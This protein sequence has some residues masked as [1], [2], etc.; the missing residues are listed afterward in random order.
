MN[1]DYTRK[2]VNKEE[3]EGSKYQAGKTQGLWCEAGSWEDTWTER[4]H[5]GI[6][7]K[8]MRTARRPREDRVPEDRLRAGTSKGQLRLG[9]HLKGGPQ[10]TGSEGVPRCP[11]MLRGLIQGR[12]QVTATQEREGRQR[13]VWE[14]LPKDRQGQRPCGRGKLSG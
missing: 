14:L 11:T 2:K 6:V 4:W 7:W 1:F 12:I 5:W 9:A 13:P 8:K 3:I 10:E